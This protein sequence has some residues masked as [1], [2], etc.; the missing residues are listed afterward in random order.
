MLNDLLP[1]NVYYRFNPYLTEMVSMVETDEKK[2]EQLKRDAV[3][4]LRRNED[5]IHEAA[6]ALVEEKTYIQ[7][8]KD[9]VNLQR[10]IHGL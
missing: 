8:L 4:Y 9:Y 2:L 5:K 10:D 1:A 6:N 7:K 3:M